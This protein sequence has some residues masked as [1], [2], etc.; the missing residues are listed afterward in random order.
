MVL[1]LYVG[2]SRLNHLGFVAHDAML[3]GILKV[4]ELPPQCTF[5]R[6]LALLHLGVAQQLLQL[7]TEDA[8]AGV[9]GGQPAADL[10]H[11]GHRYDRAHALWPTDGWPEKLQPE[12]QGQEE[13]SAYAY[14]SS[15]NPRIHL[16]RVAQRRSADGPADRA[17][18]A[19]GFRRSP[20]VHRKDLRPGGCW[21][22][23]WGGCTSL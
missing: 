14:L 3:T 13:L 6:F 20:A 22:L 9:G 8:R 15:G 18:F 1:A 21:V 7:Q 10:H 11:V 2:F 19:R 4:S 12:E 23:L 17:P 16:G 5:W